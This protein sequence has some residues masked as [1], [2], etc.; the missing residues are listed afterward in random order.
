MTPG[1]NTRERRTA[2]GCIAVFCMVGVACGPV[3]RPDGGTGLLPVGAP[4]PD[5]EGRDLSGKAVRLSSVRGHAAVVYFYP[6]DETPGCTHEACAFRDAFSRYEAKNITVFGVSRDS[7]ESHQEFRTHHALPFPLVADEDG[8]VDRAYGV[9][10]VL[11]MSKRVTFLV[12]PDGKVVHVWP[13]VDPALH[14]DEVL[15]AAPP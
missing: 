13:D 1:G 11:G 9:P 4:A 14:A 6:K 8:S 15:S 2:L 3:K 10:N 12:G 5:L 7:L